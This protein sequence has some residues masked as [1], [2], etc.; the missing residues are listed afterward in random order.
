MKIKINSRKYKLREQYEMLDLGL[1][2]EFET[3]E[4][5]IKAIKKLDKIA[6]EYIKQEEDERVPF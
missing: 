2:D 6:K 1:D 4:E 5:A 3:Q